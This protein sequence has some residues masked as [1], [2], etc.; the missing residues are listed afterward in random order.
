MNINWAFL[1]FLQLLSVTLLVLRRIQRDFNINVHRYSSKV[2]I[3]PFRFQIKF[4]TSTVYF[5]KY[6]QISNITKIRP[7]GYELFHANG[8]TYRHDEAN[9]RVSLFYVAP[10]RKGGNESMKQ[11][12]KKGSRK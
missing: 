12:F 2:P 5:S 11:R 9:S 7:V 4:I 6:V 3:I 10:K 8:W 1:F